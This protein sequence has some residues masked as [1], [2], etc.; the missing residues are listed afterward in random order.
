M[1][2]EYVQFVTPDT[3]CLAIFVLHSDNMFLHI[4]NLLLNLLFIFNLLKNS[5]LNNKIYF[6]NKYF[7]Y[8]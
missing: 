4:S 1:Y 7:F 2:E 6:K 3:T 8:L 5:F